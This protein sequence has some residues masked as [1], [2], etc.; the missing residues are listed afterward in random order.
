MNSFNPCFTGTS[1]HTR[2][3]VMRKIRRTCF[4]PCFT[5]TSS[6]TFNPNF[7]YFIRDM[8]QSLFYWNLL[9]YKNS[10]ASYKNTF[11]V[12]ILVLL[13]PPLILCP[14]RCAH[15]PSRVSIL[16]LLEPPLILMSGG[17]INQA[18]RVSIL[19]LLEPPL[20]LGWFL[21]IEAFPQVSILVL[22]EPPLIRKNISKKLW[23]SICFNPC[24]TGTSS[25]TSG[26]RMNIK[27]DLTFQS[28]FYWNLLS[29]SG[30]KPDL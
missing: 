17:K 3:L 10:S 15:C 9:S 22:L 13:E 1:S 7:R 25:H 11:L 20:I 4:N 19:V 12:S 27:S 16:V 28:L 14:A 26:L 21:E 18:I 29:Y 2:F 5:G 23:I 8:F 30:K 24:F 6:H